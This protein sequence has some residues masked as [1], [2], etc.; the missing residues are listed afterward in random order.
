MKLPTIRTNGEAEVG[1][2][3]EE[4]A[5]RKKFGE[6]KEKRGRRKKFREEK[7]A[8]ESRCRCAKR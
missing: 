1:R 7:E 4:K 6:E 8:E 2:V 5:I 3:R